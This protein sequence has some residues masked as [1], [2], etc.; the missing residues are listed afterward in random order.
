[1]ANW[2]RCGCCL[3]VPGS[4]VILCVSLHLVAGLRDNFTSRPRRAPFCTLLFLSLPPFMCFLVS[5]MKQFFFPLRWERPCR[6]PI[7]AQI[8]K[9][10]S[11]SFYLTEWTANLFCMTVKWLHAL[12][13]SAC[14]APENAHY[15]NT[16]SAF[17]VQWLCRMFLLMQP[18]NNPDLI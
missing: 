4:S 3:P 7:S 11:I 2:S 9:N 1:M 13:P 10:S 6:P 15:E 17:L 14:C 18:S 8:P 5:W 16:Y 12:S